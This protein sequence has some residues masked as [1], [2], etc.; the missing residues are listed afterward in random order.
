VGSVQAKETFALAIDVVPGEEQGITKAIT[1][2]RRSP[3][4]PSKQW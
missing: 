4:S 1:W 2:E 3:A